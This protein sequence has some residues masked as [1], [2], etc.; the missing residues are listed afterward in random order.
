MSEKLN[1]K[2]KEMLKIAT[3]SK[4]KSI[5][6]FF[7]KFI[8]LGYTRL[9]TLNFLIKM[10]NRS[11]IK[12]QFHINDNEAL[13]FFDLKV[14]EIQK[15][16]TVAP[17]YVT[18]KQKSLTAPLSVWVKDSFEEN[19][20]LFFED[21][22][23]GSKEFVGDRNDRRLANY[24]MNT[25][26]EFFMV[27]NDEVIDCFE[28]IMQE[29][30]N[31]IVQSE[32]QNAMVL[33]SPRYVCL[34]EDGSAYVVNEVKEKYLQLKEEG[35]INKAMKWLYDCLVYY[36]HTTVC[37]SVDRFMKLVMNQD[38]FTYDD[39][40]IEYFLNHFYVRETGSVLVDGYIYSKNLTD[41][42]RVTYKKI[43]DES[44]LLLPNRKI[45]EQFSIRKCYRDEKIFDVLEA[46]N[47]KVLVHTG[48]SGAAYMAELELN[49]C[50][51]LN[52]S[53]DECVN[54]LAEMNVLRKDA[55]KCVEQ[56][57]DY[58]PVFELAGHSRK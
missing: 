49:H 20:Y 21:A 46:F 41:E 27:M 9:E 56:V 24:F 1:I 17:H 7:Y 14:D 25:M 48:C 53:Q 16:L 15:T 11:V 5:N 52:M 10:D 44:E 6:K 47:K 28:K 12:E 32:D 51:A 37:F 35:I 22:F 43:F 54:A 50:I 30:G 8:R 39:Q 40:M 4:C 38:E 31:Y 42:E 26:K 34:C 36:T 19:D 23:K 18:V 29:N 57:Y 33:L 45:V 13:K 58:M 2:Q 3:N 55:R